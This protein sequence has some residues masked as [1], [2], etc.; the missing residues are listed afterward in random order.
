MHRHKVI[1]KHQCF[2]CSAFFK[3]RAMLEKH[4]GWPWPGCPFSIF[5][6]TQLVRN[7]I[8]SFVS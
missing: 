1:H 5:P 2:G 7:Y 6:D 4:Q 8:K 3:S